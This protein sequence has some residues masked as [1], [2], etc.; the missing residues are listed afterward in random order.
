MRKSH[1]Q[2]RGS[3]KPASIGPAID[4]KPKTDPIIPRAFPRL[5]SGNVSPINALA[6]GNIPPAPTFQGPEED[7]MVRWPL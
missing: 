4:E 2:P 1:C 6:T 3:M 5:S 7:M